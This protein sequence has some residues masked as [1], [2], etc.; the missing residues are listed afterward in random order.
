MSATAPPLAQ[1]VNYPQREMESH[2]EPRPGA[3]RIDPDWM[4][5]GVASTLLAGS[6]LLL[7]GKRKAGLLA[8]FA[9]TA[10]AMIEHKEIV[11]EW[12]ETLPGYLENA[13]RMLDQATATIDDLNDKRDKIMSLLGK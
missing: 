2:D 12:W 7:T 8:T 9:G 11:R 10:L 4:R 13:Q 5:I 6:L 3:I 1:S